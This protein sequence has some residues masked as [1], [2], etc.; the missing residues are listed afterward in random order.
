MKTKSEQ[1]CRQ[2]V[3][4]CSAFLL[5]LVMALSMAACG[6]EKTQTTEAGQDSTSKTTEKTEATD[7]V[8]IRIGSLKGPTSMGLV[9]MRKGVENGDA[10]YKGKYTFTMET[11]ADVIAASVVSGDLDIALVPANLAAVLYKKTEG[12][13]KVLS[14]NT[15]GV[16]ECVTGDESIKSVKDLAG[17]TVYSTGQGTTPEYALRFLLDQYGVKDCTIE[18]K[19]EATEIASLLKEDATKIAVLPQPFATVAQAQNEA[20]KRAFTLYDAWSELKI[21]SQLVTGL[22]IVRSEFLEQH[23]EA[24]KTFMQDAAKS[25]ETAK[26]D[27][28]GT[29][30][31]IAEY[32]IIEKAPIAKKALPECNI[33]STSGEEMKK[34]V[35]GYLKTLFD[36]D[37]KSVGGALPGDDFYYL[38]E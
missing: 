37:A 3:K 21:D 20:V 13:V 31:L 25:V 23:P 33:V 14:I 2:F 34:I 6:S 35:S 4:K 38:G 22:T 16:L 10:G 7:D 11:Q 19:S 8:T 29:A 24:V 12:K 5:V 26:T 15:M 18:F 17:K 9:N 1:L 27:L 36:Q 30:E 32:G 28:D